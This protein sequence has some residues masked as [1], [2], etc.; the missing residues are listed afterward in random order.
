MPS[1]P[2]SLDTR[3]L[4]RGGERLRLLR[5]VANLDHVQIDDFT[6]PCIPDPS[7]PDFFLYDISWHNFS[8]GTPDL[9]QLAAETGVDVHDLA[10][11]QTTMTAIF[12]QNARAAVA[13]KSQ[14]AY[15][16]TLRWRAR[17]DGEA[18]KALDGYLRN[19]EGCLRRG[20]PVPG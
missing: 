2:H 6:R 10:T 20:S 8:C 19:P 12:E 11:L 14:H 18:A 13:V 5:D 9:P 7:G 17:T 4:R 1:R 15:E 3:L 16:R